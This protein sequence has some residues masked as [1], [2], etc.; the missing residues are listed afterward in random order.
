VE[1][2]GLL[3][4][5]GQMP[6]NREED[7]RPRRRPCQ[8]DHLETA[9]MGAHGDAPMISVLVCPYEVLYHLNLL[10]GYKALGWRISSANRLAAQAQ[11]VTLVTRSA[12]MAS[13]GYLIVSPPIL[14]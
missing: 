7:V 12:R 4:D 5:L 11:R 9:M 13:P 3:D 10:A 1:G 14:D 6:E 2:V 8:L